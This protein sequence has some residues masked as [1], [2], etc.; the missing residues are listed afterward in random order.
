[1]NS[2][3]KDGRGHWPAGVSRS[4]MTPAQ[5]KRWPRLRNKLRRTLAHPEWGESPLR[6]SQRG[7]AA[8]I[9][10]DA[11]TVGR[12]LAGAKLPMAAHVAAIETWFRERNRQ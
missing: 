12:W 10:V 11:R 7:L 3:R 8:Y 9:G 4:D 6:A 1:M 5:R 2:Q